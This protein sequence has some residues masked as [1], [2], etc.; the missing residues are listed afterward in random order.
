LPRNTPK[1]DFT[2]VNFDEL[3]DL[4]QNDC[5]K[6]VCNAHPKV[7]NLLQWL[8]HYAPSRM[9]GTGA[10]VFA[11]FKSCKEAQNVLKKLPE[12]VTG[13]VC[14]GLDVSPLHEQLKL[15]RAKG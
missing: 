7:A 5:E 10:S 8:V 11:Q 9:T 2:L 15:V 14:K 6:L 12:D 3:F 13:F 4:T 1:I